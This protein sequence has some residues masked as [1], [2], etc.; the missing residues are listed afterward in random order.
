MGLLA[1]NKDILRLVVELLSSQ[2]AIPLSSTSRDLY[3]A[4]RRYALS[5]IRIRSTAQLVRMHD[6]LISGNN[7]RIIHPKRLSVDGLVLCSSRHGS[8][9]EPPNDEECSTYSFIDILGRIPNL[10]HLWLTNC[11][12]PLSAHSELGDSIAALR[13]ITH[14]AV[15]KRAPMQWMYYARWSV[16]RA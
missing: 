5:D 13:S 2:D 10:E 15:E 7:K 1:L 11:E 4:S 9:C 6:Y 3:A 12:Q 16:G 14:L 8:L